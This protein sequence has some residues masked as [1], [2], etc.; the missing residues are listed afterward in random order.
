MGEIKHITV[1]DGQDEERHESLWQSFSWSPPAHLDMVK[2]EETMEK[3]EAEKKMEERM[4]LKGK[5]SARDLEFQK[6]FQM[7]RRQL[8]L[9]SLHAYSKSLTGSDKLHPPIIMKEDPK[10]E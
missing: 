1:F 8:A 3:N 9:K 7:K 10:E 5:I 2:E 6:K 4:K